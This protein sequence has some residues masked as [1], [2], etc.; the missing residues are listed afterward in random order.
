MYYNEQP[1]DYATMATNKLKKKVRKKK[2]LTKFRKQLINSSI[3]LD[4]TLYKF[5]KQQSTNKTNTVSTIQLQTHPLIRVFR[6][7]NFDFFSSLSIR[8]YCKLYRYWW[9]TLNWWVTINW[10]PPILGPTN[11]YLAF[12]LSSIR[13]Y[14]RKPRLISKCVSGVLLGPHIC[15]DDNK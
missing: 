11:T 5:N 9:V 4:G 14:A 7:S 2:T 8:Y 1:S 15:N 12:S 6:H 3:I 10:V 13:N